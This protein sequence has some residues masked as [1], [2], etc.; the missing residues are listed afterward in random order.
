MDQTNAES[1]NRSA[2]NGA[3]TQQDDEEVRGLLEA[4]DKDTLVTV[5]EMML[6]GKGDFDDLDAATV[7]ANL[8]AADRSSMSKVCLIL[9]LF[10]YLLWW[11][12]KVFVDFFFVNM[13]AVLFLLLGT[14][15]VLY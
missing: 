12:F 2:K 6:Q 1:R 11:F 10:R 13:D 5:M 9:L 14:R 8:D 3:D 15:Y 7:L 4:C